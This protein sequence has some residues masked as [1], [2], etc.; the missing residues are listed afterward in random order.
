[1][2]FLGSGVSDESYSFTVD[3]YINSRRSIFFAS[4]QQYIEYISLHLELILKVFPKDISKYIFEIRAR[5]YVL[6]VWMYVRVYVYVH[7]LV[8]VY[9]CDYVCV[10]VCMCV[11]GAAGDQV[12]LHLSVLLS[13]PTGLYT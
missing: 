3:D 6:C 11:K 4:L 1:M 9:V 13:T 10:C 12:S 8:C 7:G 2:N 5:V